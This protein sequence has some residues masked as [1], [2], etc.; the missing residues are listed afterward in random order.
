MASR[1]NEGSKGN[2]KI[3][4]YPGCSLTSS[5]R[6][7]GESFFDIA[8]MFSLEMVPLEDWSCCGSSPAHSTHH[9]WAL[10]LAARNLLL[11]EEQGVNELMV[12]CPSCFVRLREAERC[13]R[14]DEKKNQEVERAFGKRY[15]GGVKLRFFLETIDSFGLKALKEK[16]KSPLTGLKGALY[17]GCLLS[18]PEWITGF[19]VGPYEE[20]LE[21][22]FRALGGEPVRWGYDRQC[23]G[24]HLAVTKPDMVNSMVDRIRDHARRAGANCLVVFCPLCQVNL[25][26]RGEQVEALPVLYISEIMGLAAKSP[27]AET[28]LKRHLI[29]PKPLLT[30][31]KLL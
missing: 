19:D 25:E 12:M 21:D 7:M 18:R 23:C 22:L 5:A 3:H 24:A 1:G 6:E 15:G 13:I 4:Y 27:H 16:V 28:W 9:G 2:S 14:E 8:Q 29:D 31:L 20:F 17:Y 30:S 10:L 26:L 11:A